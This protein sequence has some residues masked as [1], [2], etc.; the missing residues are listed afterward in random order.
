MTAHHRTKGRQAEVA[1]RDY[2][3][4]AG[5]VCERIPAGATL[6]R[7]DLVLVDTRG[8]RIC[9]EVKNMRDA[10][11]AIAAGLRELPAE[12]ANAGAEF[13][14]VVQRPHGVPH[15]AQFRVVMTLETFARLLG[16]TT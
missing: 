5:L 4:A 9:V 15:P 1:A 3:N 14:V 10:N 11:A 8:R 16:A 13:G 7:G 6:D 12:Q 2:L